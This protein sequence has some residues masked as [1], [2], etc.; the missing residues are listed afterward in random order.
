[1]SKYVPPH[2]RNKNNQ[3]NPSDSQKPK[4]FESSQQKNFTPS[5]FRQKPAYES[6]NSYSALSKIKDKEFNDFKEPKS[7]G[8]KAFPSLTKSQSDKFVPDVG[9]WGKKNDSIYQ[10]PVPVP[11][12]DPVVVIPESVVPVKQKDPFAEF[13][14]MVIKQRKAEVE[15]FK[16]PFD[17]DDYDDCTDEDIDSEEEDSEDDQ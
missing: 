2:L 11:K 6:S 5:N 4:S 16:N 15:E 10:K 3:E 13:N 8:S 12:I 7:S 14:P 17:D 1:M 9:V